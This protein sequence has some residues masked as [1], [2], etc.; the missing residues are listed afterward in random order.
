M[1]YIECPHCRKGTITLRTKLFLG[2]GR[3]VTCAACGGKMSVPGLGIWV[4]IPLISAI[5]AVQFAIE[6]GILAVAVFAVGAA[7]SGFL[8]YRCLPLVPR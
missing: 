1:R 3:T 4:A 5:L 8:H 2:P 6:S 7:L